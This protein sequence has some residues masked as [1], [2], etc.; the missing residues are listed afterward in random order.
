M[1]G[2]ENPVLSDRIGSTGTLVTQHGGRPPLAMPRVEEDRLVI[3]GGH[4]D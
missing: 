4:G 2:M 3:L 1:S